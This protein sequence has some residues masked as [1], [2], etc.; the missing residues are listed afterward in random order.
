MFDNYWPIEISDDNIS[1]NT[2]FVYRMTICLFV[3]VYFEAKFCE[4]L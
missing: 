4:A 1:I 3:K 2:S